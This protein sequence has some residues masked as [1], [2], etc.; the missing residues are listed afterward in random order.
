MFEEILKWVGSVLASTA[1]FGI[2]VYLMRSTLTK[3]IGKSIEHRFDKKIE[4]FKAEIRGNEKE[5]EQI[6]AFM[7][8]IRKE[9][10][11]TLQ[12]KRFE[13]AETL[14]RQRQFLGQF[15]MLVEY[16]KM[17]NM[18]EI[19]KN[20]NDPQIAKFIKAL[21]DPVD[22]DEKL[23]IYGTFDR[24]MTDLYLSERIKKLFETY[25]YIMLNAVMI[26]KILSL[27]NL[28]INPDLF[29]KD[30][31]KNMVIE[32]APLSKEGFDQFGDSYAFHWTNY[33]YTEILTEL[34]NELL[35]ITSMSKDTEAATQLALDSRR[36][37]ISLHAIFEKSGLS[38]DLIKSDAR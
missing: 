33:F 20:R 22:I 26:M 9:R 4:S 11:S 12:A 3:L 37:Q 25:Q 15:T 19:L 36:A 8:S 21:T 29:K 38:E 13:A 14:M 28:D 31:I 30:S 23:K 7:G 24:T 1:V 16:V 18:E 32:L 10:D 34:R 6:R 27:P 35:G 17:L 2:V 5:F